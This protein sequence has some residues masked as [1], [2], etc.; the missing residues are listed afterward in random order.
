MKKIVLAL[1]MLS[2]AALVVIGIMALVWRARTGLMALLLGVAMLVLFAISRLFKKPFPRLYR[3]GTSA[4]SILLVAALAVCA[5]A[6]VQIMSRYADD[7]APDDAVMIVLGC[8]LSSVDNTS[9]SLVMNRRLDA[10]EEYLRENPG[11]VCI[12]SGGQGPDEK[13]SEAKAMYDSLVRR[14]IDE[15]RLYKEERSTSTQENIEFSKELILQNGLADDEDNINAIIVTDGFHQ[16]RAHNI[17]KANMLNCFTVA[18]KAP[19]GLVCIY[20][21]REIPGI[22]LQVWL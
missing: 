21:I 11:T 6:S 1:Y 3:V 14:G 18:S 8:G 19:F 5:V 22:V 4:V 7:D 10:A 20:W 12:L 9:P 15:S 2:A 13:V 16:Y 17:G